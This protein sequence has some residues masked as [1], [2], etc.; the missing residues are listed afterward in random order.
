MKKNTILPI[1]SSYD[2]MVSALSRR[3]QNTLESILRRPTNTIAFDVV[4]SLLLACGAKKSNKGRTSGS[5]IGYLLKVGNGTYQILFHR[6][7]PGNELGKR[8][9]ESIRDVLERIQQE[10]GNPGGGV[11]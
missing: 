2:S 3:H 11:L 5:R 6:P 8:T 1:A 7:H 10:Q 9:V 4:D